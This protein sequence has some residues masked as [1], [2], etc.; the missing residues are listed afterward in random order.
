MNLTVTNAA[1][2]ITSLVLDPASDG[3]V[4]PI[5]GQPTVKAS[6]TDAGANDTH[7]CRFDVKDEVLGTITAQTVAASSGQCAEGLSAPAAGLYSITVTVTDDDLASD[8]ASFPTGG[9]L[10]VIY[11]P[12]AGF[13]TGGGWIDSPPGACGFAACTASTTGKATFGFVSKYVAQKDKASQVL[14]G[15]TEFHFH[16]GGLSFKSISYEWLIVNGNS[17]R[18]QYKGEGAVNGVSNYGFILT[19]YDGSP[20]R[21]RIKIWDVGTGVVVYDN[22]FN[23]PDTSALATTLGGGSIIVHVKK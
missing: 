13:V 21:F 23:E 11:D 5:S 6:F 3:H 7:T 4:Y 2:S 22:Q 8:A 20:D 15:N 12:S 9:L 10:I 17:G 1:P 14:T 16:A 19:A 18:A